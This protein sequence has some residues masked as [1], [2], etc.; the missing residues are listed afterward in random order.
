MNQDLEKVKTVAKDL[1]KSEPSAPDQE[2]AGFPLAARCLDKC[3]AELVGWQ[4]EY[5]FNCPMDQEFL[6]DAELT[7]EDF[8]SFVATGA[9]DEEVASWLKEHAHART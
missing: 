4:G 6:N 3:R 8:K 9:S 2:L 5:K 7:A 1:R